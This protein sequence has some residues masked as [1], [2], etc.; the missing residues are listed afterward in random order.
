MNDATLRP[1]IEKLENLFSI[2]NKRYYNNEL[3]IPVITVSPDTT[4]GTYGWCTSWKAWKR[5][6]DAEAGYYEINM[7]AEHLSRSFDELCSTLLHEMTHLYNLQN[8]VQD[9][10]RGGTYHNKKFK[11]VAEQHGLI[12]EQHHKYGWTITTLNNESKQFIEQLNDTGFQIYRDSAAK[13]K[14]KEAS[15]QSSRK[16]VCPCCGLIVRATKEVHVQCMECEMELE[17]E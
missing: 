15:A 13:I 12:I 1:V 11:Q 8:S 5:T 17:E 14:T 3:E 2:F 10:S 7:C 9:T 16:Y 4:K 6:K